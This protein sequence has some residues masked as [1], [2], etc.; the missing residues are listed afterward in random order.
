M[1]SIP[2]L[3]A[4]LLSRVPMPTTKAIQI[5]SDGQFKDKNPLP[6]AE[7]FVDNSIVDQLER[8]GDID[9]AYR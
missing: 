6:N 1:F 7:S 3:V 2:I 4:P 9:S 5:I 8:S